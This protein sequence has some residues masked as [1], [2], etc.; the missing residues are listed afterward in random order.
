MDTGS[1]NPQTQDSVGFRPCC[2]PV[3][4]MEWTALEADQHLDE[5]ESLMTVAEMEA[6]MA[7]L[8]CSDCLDESPP[9]FSLPPPPPPPWL[10]TLPGCYG[11]GNCAD[12]PA[13]TKTSVVLLDPGQRQEEIAR[14][15]SG[16][17]VTPEARAQADRLLEGV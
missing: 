11:T 17:Q 6:F 15:L 13:V 2:P 14:M 9:L 3:V 16:A 1:A 10:D 4:G 7:N 12:L 8:E 5:E